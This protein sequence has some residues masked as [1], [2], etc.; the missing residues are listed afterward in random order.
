VFGIPIG[1]LGASFEQ[2]MSDLNDDTAQLEASAREALEEAAASSAS[3]S[4]GTSLEQKAYEFVNGLAGPVSK[5]F[6]ILI[7]FLIF[8]VVGVGIWQTVQGHENDWHRV[9]GFGVAVFTVE[10]LMRFIGA[11]ADPEF[12]R[13]GSQGNAI[14]ARLRFVVSFYSVVDLLAIVPFYLAWA[15]PNSIVDQYDEYLRM[16]RILRLVK[17]RENWPTGK[18]TNCA[19][20][21]N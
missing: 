3:R 4:L 11:G 9:E 8:L 17:V 19:H 15:L 14:F 18:V 5:S 12:S 7:Y 6:E 21:E 2:V 10:Y 16:F 1:V 13:P 20:P